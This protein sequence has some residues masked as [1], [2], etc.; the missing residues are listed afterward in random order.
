MSVFACTSTRRAVVLT[1]ITFTVE[2]GKTRWRVLPVPQVK[3]LGID[4]SGI[5]DGVPSVVLN[6]V[7]NIILYFQAG[8][9][10]FQSPSITLT[11]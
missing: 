11:S 4:A 3:L 1:C 8:L 9:L 10:F 5:A 6:L 7:W 2:S